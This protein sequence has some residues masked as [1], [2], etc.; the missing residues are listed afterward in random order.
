MILLQII[1][2]RATFLERN[3]RQ[4]KYARELSYKN[5]VDKAPSGP[6]FDANE[7]AKRKFLSHRLANSNLTN[8]PDQDIRIDLTDSADELNEPEQIQPRLPRM[9]ETVKLNKRVAFEQNSNATSID[10]LANPGSQLLNIQN[11]P[12][13]INDSQNVGLADAHSNFK[14]N[15]I[16]K[17]QPQ[18][19]SILKRTPINQFPNR[20]NQNYNFKNDP[21]HTDI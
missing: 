1:R 8:P 15:L 18:P 9:I 11:I 14:A 2:I 20:L 5:G 6:L 7:M 12:A 3:I 10:N 16:R 4:D 17:Q 13:Q 21:K 19:E